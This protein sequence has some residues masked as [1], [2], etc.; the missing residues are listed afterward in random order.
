MVPR[1]SISGVG[2]N[3]QIL[4]FRNLRGNWLTDGCKLRK[5]AVRIRSRNVEESQVAQCSAVW[6]WDSV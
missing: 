2:N 4:A 3:V 6:D 5:E 1:V